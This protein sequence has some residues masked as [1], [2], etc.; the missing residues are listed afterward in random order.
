MWERAATQGTQSSNTVDYPGHI[1]T[2]AQLHMHARRRVYIFVDKIN[3]QTL[4]LN[5]NIFEDA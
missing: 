4:E 1:S 5:I 2:I 3:K